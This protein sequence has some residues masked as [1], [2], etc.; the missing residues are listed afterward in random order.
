MKAGRLKQFPIR[1]IREIRGSLP[2]VAFGSAGLFCGSL[3]VQGFACFTGSDIA[4]F[5][6]NP[7]CGGGG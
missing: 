1:E 4:Q 7:K 3:M 6:Q 2:L 5:E